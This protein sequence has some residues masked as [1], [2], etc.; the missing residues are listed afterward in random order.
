MY[1]LE[2][3]LWAKSLLRRIELIKRTCAASK[4]EIPEEAKNEAKLLFQHQI[5]SYFEQ[6]S[7]PPTNTSKVCPGC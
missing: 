7:I 3:S 4:H 5:V 1:E 6:H 2:H